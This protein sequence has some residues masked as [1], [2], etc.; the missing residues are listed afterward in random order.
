MDQENL[1]H[2]ENTM[3]KVYAVLLHAG[4]TNAEI[5]GIV[6][7]FQ[8]AGIL[9][10]ERGPEVIPEPVHEDHPAAQT[11]DTEG[12]QLSEWIERQAEERR[13]WAIS[14][15][16]EH[17]KEYTSFNQDTVIELAGK[18]EAFVIGPPK[19]DP[20]LHDQD[21]FDTWG[22]VMTEQLSAI[23][24]LKKPS[25]PIDEERARIETLLNEWSD[26]LTKQGVRFKNGEVFDRLVADA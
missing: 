26:S 8:N 15:A 22:V 1:Y 20:D 21:A 4:H 24:F 7:E 2:D 3:G 17:L 6:S 18:I 13:A 5:S 19:E 11:E 25:E 14:T 16:I 9:F 23:H 10:R 12:P